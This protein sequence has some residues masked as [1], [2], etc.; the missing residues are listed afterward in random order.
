MPLTPAQNSLTAQHDALDTIVTCLI[1][2]ERGSCR[3]RVRQSR[4]NPTT[5]A[6]TYWFSYQ[7]CRQPQWFRT[8]WQTRR[9]QTTTQG[10]FHFGES[11][12]R[13]CLLF[14][15]LTRLHKRHLLSIWS[16]WNHRLAKRYSHLL[17]TRLAWGILNWVCPLPNQRTAFQAHN[18]LLWLNWSWLII[19]YILFIIQQKQLSEFDGLTADI[20][21][22]A[23]YD[24]GRDLDIKQTYE[25]LHLKEEQLKVSSQS[26]DHR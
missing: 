7:C 14:F 20:I 13:S 26:N 16:P 15:Q 5:G 19:Y 6:G 18:L 8:R 10:M 25:K 17:Y 11:L 23:K 22:A 9:S 24:A 3:Q 2:W 21:S 12:L 1:D 4:V